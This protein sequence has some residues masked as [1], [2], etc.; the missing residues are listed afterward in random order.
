[1]RRVRDDDVRALLVLAAVGE[2]RVEEHQPG[3]LALAARRRLER[4]G[5][6]PGH[7]EQD[8]LELPLELEGALRGVV[9]DERME[10]R[11]P[12]QPDEPLV[13]ARVVLHRA[14]AEGIEARVD[15][16]VA[17]RELR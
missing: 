7:L 1:M 4:H 12:R 16:E 2:V 14:A 8:L 11:E 15:P 13:D 10:L 6:E 9:L 5:V 3:E 17:R